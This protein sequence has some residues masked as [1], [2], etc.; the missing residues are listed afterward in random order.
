MRRRLVSV[1]AVGVL[2]VSSAACLVETREVADPRPA[3]AEARRDATRVQGRKG[4][5]RHLNLLAYDPADRELTRVSLPMWLAKKVS[6]ESRV[7]IQDLDLDDEVGRRLARRLEG[8]KL[9]DLPL[10][11]LVEAEDDGEIVLVWL[12]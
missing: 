12:D 9:E 4:P 7:D 2:A 3:F 1:L 5:A 11:L 10:G 6:N 8:R